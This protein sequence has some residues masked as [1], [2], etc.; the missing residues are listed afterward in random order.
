MNFFPGLVSDCNLLD[1]IWNLN[2]LQSPFGL[3]FVTLWDVV[4]PLRGIA[5]W[6]EVG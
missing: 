2:V 4:K 3:Q 1:I 5:Y 6:E